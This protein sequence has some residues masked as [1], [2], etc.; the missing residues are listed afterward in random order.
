MGAA[1]AR[2]GGGGHPRPSWWYRFAS[3]AG[4]CARV[5][6]A[7]AGTACVRVCLRACGG[8]RACRCVC[9][10]VRV[11]V[12]ACACLRALTRVGRTSARLH[13]PMCVLFAS[14]RLT[15]PARCVQCACPLAPVLAAFV[16]RSWLPPVGIHSLSPRVLDDLA[17]TLP[18]GWAPQTGVYTACVPDAGHGA[19]YPIRI[20]FPPVGGGGGGGGGG[21]MSARHS[22]AAACGVVRE[23]VA[24]AA[25]GYKG[26]ARLTSII[27]ARGVQSA[28]WV[29]GC[30]L[31][32]LPQ[33]LRAPS[34]LHAAAAD[35]AAAGTLYRAPLSPRSRRDPVSVA[36]RVRF[37]CVDECLTDLCFVARLS[38]APPTLCSIA[39]QVHAS[40]LRSHPRF[41]HRAHLRC[42]CRGGG[43]GVCT[44]LC[45]R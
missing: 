24:R 21:V 30:A 17:L 45:R 15:C 37:I 4:A 16:A 33:Q 39:W 28:T 38:P 41:G 10:C 36:P 42:P 8:V 13:V 6:V 26:L 5:C 34:H 25:R 2:G 14:R 32:R 43:A 20:L 44:R 23:C 1:G 27:C 19:V 18:R 7:V 29:R 11:H 40:R 22:L 3:A 35:C 31:V 12:C 9:A